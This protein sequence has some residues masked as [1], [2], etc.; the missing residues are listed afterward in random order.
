MFIN[1][2]DLA[3]FGY[4]FLRHGKWNNRQLISEKWISMAR[5][6]GPANPAYGFCN[7]FLNVPSKTSDGTERPRPFPSAPPSSITFQGNGVNI[8]YLDWENDLVVVGRWIDGNKN[9]D[10]FLGKVIGAMK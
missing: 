10:Q 7:W 6:P 8:V 3:R 9:F 5:T 2:S 4:L 1:A